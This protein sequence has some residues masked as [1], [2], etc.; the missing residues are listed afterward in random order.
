STPSETGV[1]NFDGS[2]KVTL[3]SGASRF[4][5]AY[6]G[7][8]DTMQISADGSKLLLGST[9]FLYDTGTGAL[10]QLASIGGFFS[11]DSPT[12]L[13]DGMFRVTMNGAASRFV[14]LADDS[15][16]VRQLVV[17]DASPTSFGAAPVVSNVTM[18]PSFL[19]VNQGN[20]ATVAS[21][22]TGTSTIVRAGYK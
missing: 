10:L 22:V 20:F 3:A 15:S 5:I 7:S 17:M 14:Y 18:N 16:N 4:P 13:Y 11:S 21:Q 2:G 6:P 19:L 9:S 12:I 8:D 1:T